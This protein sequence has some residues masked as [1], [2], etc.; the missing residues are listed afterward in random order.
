MQ[1]DR[2]VE[3]GDRRPEA[4]VFGNVV[5]DRA[6]GDVLL[7]EAVHHRA[8]EA[9][10]LHATREF[11]RG[12]VGV[13]HRQ[14]GEGA[15]ALRVEN[16]R[17]GHLVVAGAGDG[18]RLLGVEDGLDAR[19][20]ERENGVV[21]PVRGHPVEPLAA[22]IEDL[23][24]EVLPMARAAGVVARLRER[25]L[26]GHMLFERNLVFHSALSILRLMPGR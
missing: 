9:H 2:H 10:V 25:L 22:E 23:A 12:G 17:F 4:A 8:L 16:R 1:V 19:S 5:V 21:D 3:L 20:V 26:D 13:L 7:G 6:V 11:R 18:D 15:V 14:G 24:G